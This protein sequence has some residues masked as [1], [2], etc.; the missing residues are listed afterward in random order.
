VQNLSQ[1]LRDHGVP[2]W[3]S[4]SDILGAQ[5]WHDEIG[6]ALNRCD[7][8]LLVLSPHSVEAMWVQRELM[9][10]LRQTRFKNRI[11]PIMCETCDPGQLSWVLP[12]L[13]IIDFIAD[14]DE[15]YRSL[16]RVWGLGYSS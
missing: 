2:V 11:V 6:H 14:V 9:F 16:M 15:G 12:S 4:G 5:Q 3:Y 8:F 13:Q 1:V 7:W 10:A